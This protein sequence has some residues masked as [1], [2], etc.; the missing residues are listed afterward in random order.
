MKWVR[1]L[2]FVRGPVPEKSPSL[3]GLEPEIERECVVRIEANELWDANDVV[4][5]AKE[6]LLLL[7]ER[8]FLDLEI[9]DIPEL[10]IID[11]GLIF[12]MAFNV[13]DDPDHKIVRNLDIPDWAQSYLEYGVDGG[14]WAEDRH[15]I[16]E[17]L[18]SYGDYALESISY[19]DHSYFSWHPEFGPGADCHE[20]TALFTR[21]GKDHESIKT[22][23]MMS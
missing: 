6:E 7:L 21:V 12:Y 2:I 18:S 3:P 9:G 8:A 5:Y 20:G 19:G 13:Q 11:D 10:H 14:L 17:W 16:E 4:E 1:N 15:L 23:R 22:E